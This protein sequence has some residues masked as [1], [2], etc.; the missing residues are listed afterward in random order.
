MARAPARGLA[1]VA[2][3]STALI[4]IDGLTGRR[5]LIRPDSDYMGERGL[6]FVPVGAQ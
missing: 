2:G 6:L 1:E 4:D 3:A 5:R